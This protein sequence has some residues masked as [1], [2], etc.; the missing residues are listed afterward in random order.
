MWEDSRTIYL[1]LLSCSYMSTLLN[2][3]QTVMKRRGQ[4]LDWK[5]LCRNLALN[6]NVGCPSIY[7]ISWYD[8]DGSCLSPSNWHPYMPFNSWDIS[9]SFWQKALCL[10]LYYHAYHWIN[11]MD[12]LTLG[13]WTSVVCFSLLGLALWTH[14]FLDIN[15]LVTY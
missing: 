14:L 3:W 2:Y 11:K 4:D 1:S 9:C 15:C 13:K 12:W 7:M 10:A 8:F 6:K 5:I